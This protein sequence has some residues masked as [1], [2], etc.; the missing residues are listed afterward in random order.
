MRGFILYLVDSW[1]SIDLYLFPNYYPH[2]HEDFEQPYVAW[3]ILGRRL[4]FPRPH[5]EYF[6][7]TYLDNSSPVCV[8]SLL[9]VELLPQTY[10]SQ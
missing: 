3:K 7:I 4:T 5:N 2:L 9:H 10:E 8:Y 6:K 1:R